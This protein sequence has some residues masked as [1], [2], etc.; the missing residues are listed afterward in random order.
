MFSEEV[1]APVGQTEHRHDLVK[2]WQLATSTSKTE[3][4]EATS[5]VLLGQATAPSQNPHT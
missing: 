5:T 3:Q 4:V 1:L 2:S